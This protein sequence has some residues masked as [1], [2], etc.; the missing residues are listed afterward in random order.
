MAQQ[1]LQIFLFHHTLVIKGRSGPGPSLCGTPRES[2][3]AIGLSAGEP[4][5]NPFLNSTK[6]SDVP[7]QTRR[8]GEA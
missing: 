4:A 3:V 8:K 2:N 5:F 1:R 6:K 7:F